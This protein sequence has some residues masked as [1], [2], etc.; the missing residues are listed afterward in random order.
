MSATDIEAGLCGSCRHARSMR[1]AR[2][3]LFMLCERATG[4]PRFTRYPPLPVLRCPG[5]EPTPP[6]LK[7]GE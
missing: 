1:S 2:G 3:S 4:D 5:H 6:P 7:K